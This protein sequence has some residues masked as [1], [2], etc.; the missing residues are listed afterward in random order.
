MRQTNDMDKPVTVDELITLKENDKT[1]YDALLHV[2]MSRGYAEIIRFANRVKK[3]SDSR[4]I[5]M[6]PSLSESDNTKVARLVCRIGAYT[7]TAA[8]MYNLFH[9][10]D[11]VSENR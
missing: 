10:C 11:T 5:I 2:C 9:L 8:D 3:V 7:A 1:V 4:K 6:V